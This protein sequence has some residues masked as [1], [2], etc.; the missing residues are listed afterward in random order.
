MQKTP[1]RWVSFSPALW[2]PVAAF[3]FVLIAT[4]V[5]NAQANSTLKL[6]TGKEIFQAAC[7]SCH[8]ADGKGQADT[9]VGFEKPK[10]FPDFSDCPG[11][12]P[13]AN[14]QWY[15]VIHD[16]GAARGFSRIMPSFGDALTHDQID[17]VIIYLRTLCGEKRWPQ[18][19]LNVPLPLFTE[20]AFPESEV[21]MTTTVN[22][23]GTPAVTNTLLIEKRLGNLNTLEVFLPS[24]YQQA[25]SG[26]WFAGIGD[27]TVGLKRTLFHSLR[28]GSIVALAGE[29]KAPTGDAS[30]GLGSGRTAW[31][32]SFSYDQLFP[33]KTFALFQFGGGSSTNREQVPAELFFRAALGKSFNQSGGLGRMWSPMTEFIASRE[34]LPG[35]RQDWDVVPQ[36]QITLSR[37]QHVRAN[38]GVDIPFTNTTGRSTQVVFY[39]LWDYFDGSWRDGWR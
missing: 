7:V 20:K 29:I 1:P 16:G 32:S 27:I 13:E 8:G 9:T 22:A 6:D 17:K 30:K 5:L 11:S 35:A 26:T 33:K 23:T 10:T 18:G 12:T 39:L 34:L 21:L 37:R 15:A 2:L 25:P 3:G 28:T 24:G 36:M 4:G 14:E 38:I 19:D 31:E